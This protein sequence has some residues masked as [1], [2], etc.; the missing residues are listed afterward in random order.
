[1]QLVEIMEQRSSAGRLRES[2]WIFLDTMIHNLFLT[3]TWYFPLSHLRYKSNPQVNCTIQC[4]KFIYV[5][6]HRKTLIS[7]VDLTLIFRLKSVF[8]LFQTGCSMWCVW[9]SWG[10]VISSSPCR[11]GRGRWPI[12]LVAESYHH[13]WELPE[14]GT[15]SCFTRG[16]YQGS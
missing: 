11:S 3:T 8:Y 4:K 14:C 5:F 6:Y 9:G 10:S 7:V 2:K 12:H 16:E 15:S 1:M 13:W